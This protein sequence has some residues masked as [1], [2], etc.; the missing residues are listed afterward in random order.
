MNFLW[1]TFI[2]TIFGNI[3]D[4]F[5]IFCSFA[6]ELDWWYRLFSCTAGHRNKSTPCL[7]KYRSLKYHFKHR[8]CSCRL[9]PKR[10]IYI[11]TQKKKSKRCDSSYMYRIDDEIHF[12][13]F[14]KS[15]LSVVT[16]KFMWL[17][18]KCFRS[19]HK[20]CLIKCLMLLQ[21]MTS[22]IYTILVVVF[23][24]ID[25]FFFFVNVFGQNKCIPYSIH[26]QKHLPPPTQY[27]SNILI[28]YIMFPLWA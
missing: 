24:F 3:F 28:M 14:I 8:K 27:L 26:V 12:K 18:I 13:N 10:N 4:I 19:L 15:S 5:N 25:L 20:N 17:I 9:I 7:R 2:G 23:A 6:W 16:F 1:K 21:Y 22:R 11:R